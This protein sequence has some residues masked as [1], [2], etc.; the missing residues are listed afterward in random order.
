MS[1]SLC[2]T[3]FES[4]IGRIVVE[5]DEDAVTGL[6]LPAHK[7]WNGTAEGSRP[8]DRCFT[9]VLSQLEQFFAGERQT[10]DVPLRSAGTP[11]QERVWQALGTIP[12]GKTMTYA[13]L[14]GRVGQPG[15][16]RA[17]GA[18]NGRN[19]IS[20]LVPCHRV[21]GTNGRLTGY[22]GGLGAKQWLLEWEARHASVEL[23]IQLDPSASA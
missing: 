8:S 13:Q 21:V 10:F 9:N 15:A 3:E 2:H 6:Y 7:G 23:Q 5:G 18:A 11:F 20:I 4:P 14:A 17:V 1:K 16:S 22:A 19:P 12:Y